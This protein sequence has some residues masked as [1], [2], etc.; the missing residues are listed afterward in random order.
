M[1]LG[2][3][4]KKHYSQQ[5]RLATTIH[6][7]LLLRLRLKDLSDEK[8]ERKKKHRPRLHGKEC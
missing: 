1:Y 7:T 6:Y 2:A 3:G 5:Q 8:V 4:E